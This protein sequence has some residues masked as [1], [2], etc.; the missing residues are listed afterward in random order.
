M[1]VPAGPDLTWE[2]APDTLLALAAC[3][4]DGGGSPVPRLLAHRGETALGIAELRPFGPGEVLSPVIELLALFLPLGADRVCLALPGRVWSLDDPLTPVSEEEGVDRRPAVTLGIADGH[5][6][7]CRIQ[8]A[9]H[10]FVVDD[11]GEWG[12][13]PPLGPDDRWEAPVLDALGLL[14]DARHDL[15]PRAGHRQEQLERVLVLGHWLALAPVAA[16]ELGLVP[17][18]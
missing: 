2:E 11:V 10:P 9:L 14:L 15:V 17:S 1:V 8:G 4:L 3:D 16:T 6:D 12:W 18:G 13:E 7:A 5:G